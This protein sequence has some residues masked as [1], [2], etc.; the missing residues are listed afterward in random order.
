M[1]LS[2]PAQPD[3][4]LEDPAVAEEHD[5]N[6][7]MP[8]WAYI[9]ATA[10]L[11]AEYILQRPAWAGAAVLEL[12]CGLGLTGLAALTHGM[13]VTFSDQRLEAVQSALWNARQNGLS[14]AQGAIV[15][16]FTDTPP[17]PFDVVLGCEVLYEAQLHAPMLGF[18][19]RSLALRGEALFF[20]PGRGFLLP[21]V[22]R[23]RAA[24]F[25]VDWTQPALS[26]P[27]VHQFN[28]V[29]LTRR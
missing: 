17:Q 8:Y 1:R 28:V 21:F 23:A 16:W 18:L 11:S 10:E 3:L 14:R 4:L 13:S 6:G 25:D 5:R 20:D 24:G 9:W 12:G 19:E 22:E 2:L 27:G 7:Y 15:D 29:R 26:H